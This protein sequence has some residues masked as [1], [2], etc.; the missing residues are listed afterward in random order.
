MRNTL[1]MLFTFFSI[2]I[3]AQSKII[4][5]N[6]L[7]LAFGIA[8][9]GIEFSERKN[10]S[11]TFSALYYSKSDVAGFGVGLEKKNY[12]QTNESLKGFHTGPSVGYLNLS[13]DSNESLR[14]FSVGVEIGHQWF[15]SKNFTVDLFSGA[16]FF[17]G[18]PYLNET[19]S[20]GIGVISRV[21]MVK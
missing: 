6:P 7:G 2:S 14:V 18:S 17:T 11:T 19:L 13:N 1:I 8:N 10:Q 4:K 15:L 12:F 16:V 5:A 3:F 21:C 20:A 9:I